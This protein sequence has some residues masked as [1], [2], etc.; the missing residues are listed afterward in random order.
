MHWKIKTSKHKTKKLPQI[1]LWGCATFR[2]L[3]SLWYYHINPLQSSR[4][5]F[6]I[7]IRK[8]WGL[9]C[10]GSS[11]KGHSSLTERELPLFRK[12][13][14]FHSSENFH[15]SSRNGVWKTVPEVSLPSDDNYKTI[16]CHL[17]GLLI[18]IAPALLIR[19]R[20]LTELWNR[21]CKNYSW[22]LNMFRGC[23]MPS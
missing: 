2:C 23:K 8:R 19:H 21:D 5:C 12:L 17:G 10:G 1:P 6:L 16:I 3:F 11:K 14:L 9:G 18:H 4:E 7:I 20:I 22:H 13:P 15:C